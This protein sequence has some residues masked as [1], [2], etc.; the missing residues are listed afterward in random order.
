MGY[1]P[2]VA[3][4]GT[5]VVSSAGTISAITLGYAGSG[6]RSGIGQTVRVAIQ[7]SSLEG[8]EVVRYGTATI[9]SAGAITGIAITNTNVIYKP[10]DIQNVGYNSATGITT[11]TTAVT[12]GLQNGEAIKLSGIAFTCDYA[13]AVSIST[14]GYTTSTGIMTVTTYSAHGLSTT[15]SRSQAIFTGLAFTC[16]LDGGVYQHIYPRNKDRVFNTSIPITKDGTSITVTN[17]V[18][19]PTVGIM[20]V[21]SASHGL[22]NGDKVRFVDNS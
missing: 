9:G 12:H 1:Q 15:G 10:R 13:S 14:V 17:A 3:A 16:A 20:T 22:S 11:I 4:G 19:N 8:A 5:A 7:T 2:I 18:Y 6:Y 21:T